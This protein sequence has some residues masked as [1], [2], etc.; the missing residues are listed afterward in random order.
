[1]DKKTTEDLTADELV[2]VNALK[3]NLDTQ[4]FS[5]CMFSVRV[6]NHI[7]G[8]TY[9]KRTIENKEITDYWTLAEHAE[10]L[11]KR[12]QNFGVENTAIY[13]REIRNSAENE[14]AKYAFGH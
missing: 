3:E 11:E 13:Y 4:N 6:V 9:K 7:L 14:I 12:A 10:I 1:M 8:G 5:D 2:F